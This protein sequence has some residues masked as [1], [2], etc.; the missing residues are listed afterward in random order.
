M[1]WHSTFLQDC[2][3]LDQSLRQTRDGGFI[4]KQGRGQTERDRRLWNDL[5]RTGHGHGVWW[6][7]FKTGA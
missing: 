3:H 1:R 5:R 4:L 2:P 6:D 7:D